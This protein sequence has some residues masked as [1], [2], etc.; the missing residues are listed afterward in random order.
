MTT[1][2]YRIKGNFG[3]S[4]TFKRGDSE[5]CVKLGAGRRGTLKIGEVSA[6]VKGGCATLCLSPLP[7]GI[8]TPVFSTDSGE[9]RLEAIRKLGE[10]LTRHPTDRNLTVNMLDRIER[11]EECV[12]SLEC[13]VAELDKRV[14]GN[15]IFG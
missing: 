7:D 3:V 15:G 4:T 1:V 12:S 14:R 5:L 6:E 11:L 10:K 13:L 9:V 8:Y 2:I